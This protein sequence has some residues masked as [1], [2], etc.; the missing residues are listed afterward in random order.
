M[1]LPVMV[2]L[3]KF[4]MQISYPICSPIIIKEITVFNLRG[5]VLFL[6]KVTI[7]NNNNY[8]YFCGK[9]QAITRSY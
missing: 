4:C 9:R 3:C 1:I 7:N 8:Y 6:E 2:E 5:F